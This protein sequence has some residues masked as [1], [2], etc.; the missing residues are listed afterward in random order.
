MRT[1]NLWSPLM[2]LHHH[3]RPIGHRLSREAVL[4][5]G[6]VLVHA[7]RVVARHLRGEQRHQSLE[8]TTIIEGLASFTQEVLVK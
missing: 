2:G 4:H 6:V 3:H 8:A 7:A 5:E 1:T